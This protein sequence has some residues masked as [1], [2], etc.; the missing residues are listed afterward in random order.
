MERN[1]PDFGG[2]DIKDIEE[3]EK[4]ISERVPKFNQFKKQFPNAHT[5]AITIAR[6][7]DVLCKHQIEEQTLVFAIVISFMGGPM[8][9]SLMD[10]LRV[11]KEMREVI[12]EYKKNKQK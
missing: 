10:K 5:K 12:D 3:L 7:A 4:I 11:L 8:M 6:I 9:K 1:K 2:M